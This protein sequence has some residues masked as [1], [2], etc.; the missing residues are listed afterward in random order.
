MQKLQNR[1]TYALN[2]I[3]N[4]TYNSN[5]LSL[6]SGELMGSFWQLQLSSWH[7]GSVEKIKQNKNIRKETIGKGKTRRE[8]KRQKERIEKTSEIIKKTVCSP[9]CHSSSAGMFS[10]A[11]GGGWK[12]KGIFS[13]GNIF[14]RHLNQNQHFHLVSR[15]TENMGQSRSAST[16]L[17][18]LYLPGLLYT[19]YRGPQ[20]PSS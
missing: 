20:R 16:L 4:K 5:E 14:L 17:F 8:K 19:S 7:T 18:H 6:Y 15:I 10:R 9:L 13:F 11:G 2:K 12:R 1:A 3:P